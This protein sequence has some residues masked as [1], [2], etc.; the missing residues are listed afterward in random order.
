M[1]DDVASECTETH[2]HIMISW[3]SLPH[4]IQQIM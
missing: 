4:E 3:Q 2:C 1:H